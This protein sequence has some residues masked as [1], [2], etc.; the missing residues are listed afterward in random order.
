[1]RQASCTAVVVP[2]ACSPRSNNITRSPTMGASGKA[3]VRISKQLTQILRHSGRSEGLDIRPDGF[4]LLD[5]V[6]QLPS[7][8]KLKPTD[9]AIREIVKTSDKQR[10]AI[11]QEADGRTFIRANQGHSMEGINMDELCG[12]PVCELQ[13]DEVCCHG[14]YL[15]H[16]DSIMSEGLKAGGKHGQ[17]FRRHVH[18]SV[19]HPGETVVSGMRPNC[20]IAVYVDLKRAALQ[21]IRFYR[22]ENNVILSEGIDGAVP[23]GFIE[24]VWHIQRRMQLYPRAEESETAQAR[25]EHPVA[26]CSKEE[27]RCAFLAYRYHRLSFL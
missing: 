20:Q 22:S 1:V 7:M 17:S 12:T 11:L 21:G 13:E 24:R 5:D 25:P 8:M 6:M 3:H 2:S 27:L 14:T 26:E 16:F 19:R 18:F 10:F 9:E 4:A 23:P 15:Q